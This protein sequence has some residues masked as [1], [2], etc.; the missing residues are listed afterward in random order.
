MTDTIGRCKG[1]C[2]L[3]CNILNEISINTTPLIKSGLAV[4]KKNAKIIISIE[5][6]LIK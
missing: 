5:T 3:T 6:K 1:F 4:T 2:F